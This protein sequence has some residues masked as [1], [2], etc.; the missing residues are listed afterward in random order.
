MYTG[1]VTVG[2]NA[3]PPSRSQ[4]VLAL[5]LAGILGLGVMAPHWVWL[6]RFLSYW[7][8]AV[9]ENFTGRTD[10]FG[11]VEVATRAIGV[12]SAAHAI[13]MFALLSL[14]L[15]LAFGRGRAFWCVLR[16]FPR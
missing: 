8:G 2:S 10:L 14:C 9:G 16:R 6:A 15:V 3:S 4:A 5:R 13:V 7:V 12:E 11:A 1:F